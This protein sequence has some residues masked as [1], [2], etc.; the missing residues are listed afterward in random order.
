MGIRRLKVK[1]LY[2][3]IRIYNVKNI[4][5]FLMSKYDNILVT[6]KKNFEEIKR[7]LM[8]IKRAERN[9]E[10]RCLHHVFNDVNL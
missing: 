2:I 7:E 3:I 6:S 5:E 1:K 4:H 10:N 8:F 9:E